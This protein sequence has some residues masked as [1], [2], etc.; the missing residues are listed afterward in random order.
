VETIQDEKGAAVVPVLRALVGAAETASLRPFHR[1][2][3]TSGSMVISRVMGDSRWA[4][5]TQTPY[6]FEGMSLEVQKRGLNTVR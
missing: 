5:A 2:A 6:I 3:G 4:D 1:C